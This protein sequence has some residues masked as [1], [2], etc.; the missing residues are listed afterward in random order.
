MRTHKAID[1]KVLPVHRLLAFRSLCPIQL[2]DGT[3][4]ERRHTLQKRLRGRE[5]FLPMTL[6]TH[7][8]M[9]IGLVLLRIPLSDFLILFSY[10]AN[11]KHILRH[12]RPFL[13]LLC[14]VIAIHIS[15]FLK[16]PPTWFPSFHTWCNGEYNTL[17]PQLLQFLRRKTWANQF[18]SNPPT[19]H[20]FYNRNKEVSSSALRNGSFFRHEDSVPCLIHSR[21]HI[22][23][24]STPLSSPFHRPLF[25]HFTFIQEWMKTRPLSVE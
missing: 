12:F 23:Q 17:W 6:R 4:L 1:A 18:Q 25:A 9:L 15:P 7:G 22:E 20:S 5:V 14:K 16:R 19:V 10:F 8:Y 11:R 13:R 21:A 2:G 3:H 24:I